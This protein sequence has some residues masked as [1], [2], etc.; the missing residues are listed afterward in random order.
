MHLR[1][2][3]GDSLIV[4]GANQ[5]LIDDRY[6]RY[7][8]RIVNFNNRKRENKKATVSGFDEITLEENL[9]LYDLFIDKHENTLYRHRPNPQIEL[10]KEGRNAFATLSLEDQCYVI[11]QVLRLFWCGSPTEGDLSLIGGRPHSGKITI[12]KNISK[13]SEFKL[14]HQS[15]TGVFTQEVDLLRI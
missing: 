8:K 5:L 2:R 4:R 10:L 14:I 7:L 13:Y 1:G 15:P 12:S 3:T 11:G 6:M 9:E